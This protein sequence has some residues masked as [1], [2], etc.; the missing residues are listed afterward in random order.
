MYQSAF[1]AN[2][3]DFISDYFIMFFGVNVPEHLYIKIHTILLP[4]ALFLFLFYIRV[5]EFIILLLSHLYYS[6]I[7]FQENKGTT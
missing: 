3:S 2:S 5:K 6:R 1:V 4:F 7:L